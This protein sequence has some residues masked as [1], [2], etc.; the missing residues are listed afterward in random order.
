MN[1]KIKCFNNNQKKIVTSALIT[2]ALAAL[3]TPAS[4]AVTLNVQNNVLVGASNVEVLGALYDVEF[5]DGRS[6]A[7]VFGSTPLAFS[8]LASANAASQSLLD[9]VFLD[10]PA[11]DFDSIVRSDGNVTTTSFTNGCSSHN[12]CLTFTPFEIVI[13]PSSVSDVSSSVASNFNP[14]WSGENPLDRI[15]LGQ[16][17]TTYVFSDFGS[18]TIINWARWSP[19]GGIAAVVP[20]PST[21]AMIGLGLLGLSFINRRRQ[22]KV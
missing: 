6:Y 15:Q 4:A 5:I 7:S 19:A 17:P 9:Q 10:G 11:G 21:Y 14:Q 18:P 2:I 20:E 22:D 13:F 1:K 16:Y 8:N 3:S 12:F